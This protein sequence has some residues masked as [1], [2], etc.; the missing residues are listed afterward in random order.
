[1]PRPEAAEGATGWARYRAWLLPALQAQ[2]ASEAELLDDILAGRAQLWAGAAA[3]MVTQRIREGEALCLHVW[4]AGGDLTEILE[5]RAGVEA[6]GRAQGCHYV[7]IEGRAGWSRAL[8][9]HGYARCGNEL[10]R[11]L[12]DG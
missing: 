1:M 2:C 9:K 10:K 12:S 5:M 6:W 3:A 7:T 8:R 11:M 4:L